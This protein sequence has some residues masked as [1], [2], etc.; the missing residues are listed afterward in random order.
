MGD[1][2]RTLERLVQEVL[3][4]PKYRTLLPEFIAS[5]GAREL[6]V[7]GSLKEAVKATKRKLHQVTSA[8]AQEPA[9]YS[10]WLATLRAARAEG[11]EA[12]E[13]ACREVMTAHASSRE[14]LPILERFYQ[15]GLAT[16]APLGSV[17]DVACGL[18]PLGIHWMP[19]APHARYVA[20]DVDTALMAF[21]QD[22]LALTGLEGH[23]LATDVLQGLPEAGPFDVA[24][25][26]KALPCLEQIAPGCGG[27]LLAELPARA[28]LVSFP[29]ASLGGRAKGMPEHYEAYLRGLIAGKP[30]RV[31]RFSFETELA[32]LIEKEPH[33]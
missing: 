15:E 21:L 3:A 23:A 17:L 33:T 24:Y 32:F 1:Q 12:F 7:R 8:Y 5:V 19:L 16:L 27:R 18:G 13:S 20:Y 11:Q 4:S 6:N 26:L 31:Q 25:L 22:F 30:W 14:R 2:D 29:V 9:Q 28:I 10:R